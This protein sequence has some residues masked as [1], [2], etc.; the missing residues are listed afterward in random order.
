MSARYPF[1]ECRLAPAFEAD[2]ITERRLDGVPQVHQCGLHFLLFLEPRYSRGNRDKVQKYS[3]TSKSAQP[4]NLR[5]VLCRG[6]HSEFNAR[7]PFESPF[8]IEKVNV[9]I[10]QRAVTRVR[11]PLG[12]LSALRRAT[13]L[14]QRIHSR[15]P[16]NNGNSGV[17]CILPFFE[18]IMADLAGPAATWDT[19]SN[20]LAEPDAT[21]FRLGEPQRS[22]SRPE[23]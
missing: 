7:I 11:I 21:W 9:V 10:R 4:L 15:P 6:I 13:Q 23:S 12:S 1:L 20:S 2:E 5:P 8:A 19:C 18:V 16:S 14:Q 17:G 22:R 3:R